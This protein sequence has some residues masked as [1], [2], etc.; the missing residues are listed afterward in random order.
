[1]GLIFSLIDI[2]RTIK[3]KEQK[4]LKELT[5]F[6]TISI[7]SKGLKTIDVLNFR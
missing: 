6:F 3:M 7:I 5:N 1:M 4:N 2:E